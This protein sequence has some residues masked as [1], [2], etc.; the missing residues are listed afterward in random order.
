MISFEAVSVFFLILLCYLTWKQGDRLDDVED[1][2][3]AFLEA[4]EK[5]KNS[6]E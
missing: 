5:G 1:L 4:A 6:G 3:D 2:L